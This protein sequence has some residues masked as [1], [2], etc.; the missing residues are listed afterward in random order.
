MNTTKV[1]PKV[2]W[3]AV[4]IYL[5]GVVVLALVNA[6]TGEENALLIA[7]L[8]DY[9]EPFVLP[10]VPVAVQMI[11]GWFAP[12]QWRNPEIQGNL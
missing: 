6:L 3:P 10:I 12:H 4:A 7:A 5:S 8:P 2:K 1:E 11:T 9:V